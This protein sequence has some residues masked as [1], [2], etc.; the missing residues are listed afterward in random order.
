MD[1]LLPL[2]SRLLQLLGFVRGAAAVWREHELR[3]KAKEIADSP[4][5]KAELEETLRKGEL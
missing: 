1:I 4:T 2:L 3:Q 5:T